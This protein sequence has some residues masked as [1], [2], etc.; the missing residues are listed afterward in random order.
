MA[1][2]SAVCAVSARAWRQ[3]YRLINYNEQQPIT[4]S[5]DTMYCVDGKS[6]TLCIFKMDHTSMHW[7]T[8][9]LLLSYYNYYYYYK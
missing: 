7:L 6:L 8:T 5:D 3:T 4:T 2:V 1:S 9:L